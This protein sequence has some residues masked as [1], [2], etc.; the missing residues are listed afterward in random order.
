MLNERKRLNSI[1][2]EGSSR[3]VK[4]FNYYSRYSEHIYKT[5]K[6][7]VETINLFYLPPKSLFQW[8]RKFFAAS[9]PLFTNVNICNK[10]AKNSKVFEKNADNINTEYRDKGNGRSI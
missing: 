3:R 9:P 1:L 2:S 6:L 10:L 7:V 8:L 5:Y 4:P